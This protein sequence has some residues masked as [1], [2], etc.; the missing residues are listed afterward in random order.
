MPVATKQGDILCLNTTIIILVNCGSVNMKINEALHKIQK[1]L[2]APKSQYNNF[3]KYK[4]RSCEDIV[5]EAKK[6]LPDGYVLLMS[7]KAVDI[8]GHVYIEATAAL[9]G[10][11]DTISV[12]AYAR[13]AMDKKGMDA[14]QMTGT[15]SSYARKYALNGL[16]AI[17]DTKDSDSDEYKTE[18]NEKAKR[19]DKDEKVKKAKK[20]VSDYIS[21]L[22]NIEDVDRELIPL[23]S[24]SAVMLKRIAD[25]YPDL[26]SEVTK[27]TDKL[28]NG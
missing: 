27:E 2:K 20:W 12:N 1:D 22:K 14:A 26:H 19:F 16:F 11:G 23:E 6:H 4:Y 5:E 13:E 15:A 8:A 28:R 9:S 17:D 21:K 18:S 7:D 24:E 10:P 25:G 3:A